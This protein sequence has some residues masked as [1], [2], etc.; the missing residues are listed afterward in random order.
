MSDLR[1]YVEDSDGRKA[2]FEI[3]C[4]MGCRLLSAIGEDTV[5]LNSLLK[6]A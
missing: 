4:G 6:R 3:H 5:D 2:L 1:V